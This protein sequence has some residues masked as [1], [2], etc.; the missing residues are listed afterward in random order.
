MKQMWEEEKQNPS[1]KR[2]FDPKYWGS[3]FQHL[4]K[5]K[6]LTMEFETEKSVEADIDAIAEHAKAWKFPMGTN[7]VLSAD[8]CKIEKTEWEG[9]IC[10]RPR[11]D[12]TAI[13]TQQEAVLAAPR[14]DGRVDHVELSSSV[15][16]KP[17][18][19]VRTVRWEVV[20][21]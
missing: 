14:A 12:E 8:G 4:P 6:T 15:S 3:S 2:E 20:S 1:L 18:L 5:L 21:T 7:R 9:P 17:V 11:P 13:L 19:I 10:M 16:V